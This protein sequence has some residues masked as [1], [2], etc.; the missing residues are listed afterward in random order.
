MAR[1]RKSTVRDK[2][3]VKPTSF[4]RSKPLD[5]DYEPR[6]NVRVISRKNLTQ[7][8][9]KKFRSFGRRVLRQLQENIRT[10]MQGRW[11]KIQWDYENGV[12]RG[13]LA[14]QGTENEWK[15]EVLSSRRIQ[16]RPKKGY[17]RRW[18]GHVGGM[19]INSREGGPSMPMPA[20]DGTLYVR[21][22]KLPR[23]D[24]RPTAT[25]LSRLAKQE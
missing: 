14:L 1:P 3:R 25:Q 11:K 7:A 9:L 23:R 20:R 2:T 13:D 16:I 18:R 12:S 21:Q 10:N 22:V 5:A 15:V 8:E 6:P 24:P 19:T 4:P 17:E